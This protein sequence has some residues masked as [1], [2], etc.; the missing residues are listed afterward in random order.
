MEQ[1]I[2]AT[3]RP[4]SL[5]I[6]FSKDR[7]E[8]LLVQR[9]DVPVWVLPGGGID[10]GES[11]EEAAV[12]EF[13]EETGVRVKIVKKIAEYTPIN[14]LSSPAHLFECQKIDGTIR[15]SCETRAIGFF[16]LDMLPDDLFIVHRD[17]IE[18]A[19]QNNS[20]VLKKTIERVTYKEL[21]KYF[22]KHPLRVIR[23]LMTR[24]GF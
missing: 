10:D 18:D 23:Y 4:A 12:R 14:K 20:D 7:K 8:I 11:P 13:W 3:R 1:K 19:L 17:W 15:T 24:L 21:L 9:K 16:P 2:R 22:I 6:L 5:G